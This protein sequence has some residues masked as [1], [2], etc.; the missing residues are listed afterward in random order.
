M[1]RNRVDW[2]IARP[3]RGSRN[4]QRHRCLPQFIFFT[5]IKSVEIERV[6]DTKS[7]G[8]L[9]DPYGD[10]ATPNDIGTWTL[11]ISHRPRRNLRAHLFLISTFRPHTQIINNFIYQRSVISIVTSCP[12]KKQSLWCD[13]RSNIPTNICKGVSFTPSKPDRWSAGACCEC[14]NSCGIRLPLAVHRTFMHSPQNKQKTVP[15]EPT[16]FG[17][18]QFD[19]GDGRTCI[20][21]I[22][23][24]DGQVDCPGGIDELGC[25]REFSRALFFSFSF[26]Q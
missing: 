5:P 19:C 22:R 13:R 16:K 4:T 17:I 15:C 3:L 24:C 20:W 7:I 11:S 26:S 12:R 10:R 23:K 1:E 2:V 6:Q 9:R 21:E 14:D 18:P 8:G 25:H